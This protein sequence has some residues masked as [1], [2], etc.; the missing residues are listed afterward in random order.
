[1]CLILLVYYTNIYVFNY[2]LLQMTDQENQINDKLKTI[3]FP[4]LPCGLKH[5][6]FFLI[7]DMHT[8]NR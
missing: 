6:Q 2:F 3:T 1:M 7:P 8:K 4:R 5:T